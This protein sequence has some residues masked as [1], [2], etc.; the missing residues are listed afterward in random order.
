M[1][2]RIMALGMAA[3]VLASLSAS[4]EARRRGFFI[5]IPGFRSGD[6]LMLVKDLPNI[7]ALKLPDGRYID[8][9]YKFSRSGNKWIGHIGSDTEFL[10]F[11]E[12]EIKMLM[13]A[14]GLTELPPVPEKPSLFS[15][16]GNSADE[17]KND[18]SGAG[19]GASEGTS[20]SGM[21]FGWLAWLAIL[22]GIYFGVRRL[23]RKAKAAVGAVQG[24]VRAEVPEPTHTTYQTALANSLDERLAAAAASYQASLQAAPSAQAQPITHAPAAYQSQFGQARPTFGRR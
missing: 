24:M 18:T 16:G 5:P 7:E 13:T 10:N 14:A 11:G 9:G 23:F 19:A 6:S 22:A 20:S 3:I 12:A 17:A 4:A 2:N 8:L 1:T 21:S 15:F